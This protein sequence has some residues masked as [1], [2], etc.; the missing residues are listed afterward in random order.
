MQ[1]NVSGRNDKLGIN[2]IT[3]YSRQVQ[4][5]YEQPYATPSLKSGFSVA[6]N[7]SRQRELNYK[8]E[9]S[10]QAFYKQDQFVMQNIRGEIAYLYR[11]AIKV[12][13]VFKFAY[14]YNSIDDTIIKQNPNYFPNGKTSI[15]YPEVSYSIQYFNTDYNAYPSRGILAEGSVIRK[16]FLTTTL[17]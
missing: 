14:T 15:K 9:L 5:K 11:P 6:F 1:N 2:L 8:T 4:I 3:G 12:R 16:G 7:F 10:K 13:H 17:M